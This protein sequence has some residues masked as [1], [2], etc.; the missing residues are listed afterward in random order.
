MSPILLFIPTKL[1]ERNELG[2]CRRTNTGPTVLDR[3]VGDRVLGKVSADHLRLINEAESQATS[4]RVQTHGAMSRT[5]S[6]ESR[7]I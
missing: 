2:R 5:H 3:L 4:C 1:L 6:N 7:T